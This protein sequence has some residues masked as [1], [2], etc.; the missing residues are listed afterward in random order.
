MSDLAPTLQ[1]FFTERLINQSHA[2]PRTVT[3]YRDTLKMLL[4]YAQERTGK[5]ANRLDFKHLDSVL[6]EAFLMHL[7]HD[8]HNSARTSNARLAAIHSFFRFAALHH[9]EHAELIQRVLAI[10]TKR[11]GST[12][13]NYLNDAETSALLKAPD[14]SEWIGRR[15]H[16]LMLLAVQTGLR[17]SEITG[18]TRADIHLGEGAYLRCRGKGRKERATPLTKQTARVLR[19]W[20]SEQPGPDTAP[21]FPARHTGTALS[22]DAV[23]WLLAKYARTAREQCPTLRAKTVSPHVLRHSCAM[24]LLHAGVD[25]SVISLWLGHSDIRAT[26]IYL[27]ADMD[28]KEKALAR[29]NPSTTPTGRYHPPDALLAFLDAL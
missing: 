3:S 20:L 26:Q 12:I 4:S 10:P 22:S 19:S 13:V 11:F 23:Q 18:L 25:I 5:P 24:N 14:T 16:A 2:S 1:A 15:D 17:V 7:A 8:R 27:Q 29:T 6:I 28:L 21:L 9:P